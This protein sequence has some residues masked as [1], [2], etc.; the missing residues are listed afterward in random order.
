MEQIRLLVSGMT[1]QGCVRSVKRVLEAVPG[2]DAAEISLE[3]G[4]AVIQVTSGRASAADLV[5]AVERAG[6]GAQPADQAG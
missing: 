4:E 6:F 5:A 2:V 3:R 1:C